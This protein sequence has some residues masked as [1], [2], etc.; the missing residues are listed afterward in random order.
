MI[1]LLSEEDYLGHDFDHFRHGRTLVQILHF[2]HG[3]VR[4]EKSRQEEFASQ[5]VRIDGEA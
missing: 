4:C 5:R 2:L 3:L 1:R